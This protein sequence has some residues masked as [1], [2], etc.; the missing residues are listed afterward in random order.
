MG[1]IFR[2]SK[3]NSFFFFKKKIKINGGIEYGLKSVG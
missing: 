1:G 2:L 3:L